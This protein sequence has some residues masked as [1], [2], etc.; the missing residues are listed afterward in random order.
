MKFNIIIIII[1]IKLVSVINTR[2][3]VILYTRKI[4]KRRKFM[5]H[6]FGDILF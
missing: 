1:I 3:T 5:L 2:Y 4:N 6:G